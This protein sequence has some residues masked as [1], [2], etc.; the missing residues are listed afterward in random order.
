MKAKSGEL[1][2]DEAMILAK[3]FGNAALG[4]WFKSNLPREGCPESVLP[5]TV[6]IQASM[7]LGLNDRDALAKY[8]AWSRKWQTG[9]FEV[10]TA[11]R[12]VVDDGLEYDPSQPVVIPGL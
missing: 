5:I 6:R 9:G 8:G 1:S 4:R 2:A 3:S 7:I 12:S 11:D 10:I